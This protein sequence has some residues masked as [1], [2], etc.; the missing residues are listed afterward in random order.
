[1]TI[2]ESIEA[3]L[4]DAAGNVLLLYVPESGQTPTG[5]WQPVTGGKNEGESDVDACLR[6]MREETGLE[7]GAVDEMT[8]VAE[9]FL[10]EVGADRYVNKTV[11]SVRLRLER[12]P[13]T[14]SPEEHS[15]ARWFRPDDVSAALFWDSNRETWSL[16]ERTQ[17]TGAGISETT[18]P[19]ARSRTAR[20][21]A[22]PRY[23]GPITDQ[24]YSADSEV[25]RVSGLEFDQ[26]RRPACDLRHRAG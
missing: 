18:A 11:F 17:W 8:V 4:F 2:R 9:S 23:H 24:R 19:D 14:L 7:P 3:W 13:I 26:Q 15:D 20:C 22:S 1:M 16:V 6:E 12:S 21:H 5:F 10:V 25:P